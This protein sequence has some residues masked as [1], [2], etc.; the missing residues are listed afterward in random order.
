MF[1][2]ARWLFV[3]QPL[4]EPFWQAGGADE[5]RRWAAFCAAGVT[6]L[7][8]KPNYASFEPGER[9][10]LT[11]QVQQLSRSAAEA[12]ACCKLELHHYGRA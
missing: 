5:L 12:R 10:M 4:T 11:L 6:E 8:L 2:G 3:N 1:A 7:W 9:A